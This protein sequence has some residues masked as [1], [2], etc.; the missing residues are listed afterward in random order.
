MELEWKKIVLRMAERLVERA[1]GQSGLV[2]PEQ[3]KDDQ[4]S[5]MVLSV[6]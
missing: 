4:M 3:G 1:G 6:I 5:T 2:H